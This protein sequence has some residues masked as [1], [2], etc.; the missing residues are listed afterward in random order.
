M[1]ADRCQLWGRTVQFEPWNQLIHPTKEK[2][3][4]G[5]TAFASKFGIGKRKLVHGG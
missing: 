1:D 5:F 3:L 2:L 4:A